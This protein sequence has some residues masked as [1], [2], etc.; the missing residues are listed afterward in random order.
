MKQGL[1]EYRDKLKT[2]MGISMLCVFFL[3]FILNILTVPTLDDLGYQINSGLLDILHREYVQYMTWTGRT[4]A[5]LIAR[6]FLALPKIIFN[7]CN[8]LCFVHLCSLVCSHAEGK[9]HSDNWQLFLISALLIWL[10]APLFGQTCLWETGS[11]NYLWT[12]MIVMQFLLNYRL[13]DSGEENDHSLLWMFAAGIPAGW[14]NENTGGALIMMI[15]FFTVVQWYRKRLRGWMLAGL[16]GTFTGFAALLLAPGNQ[17]RALDFASTN[18]KAYDLIHDFYGMLEVFQDGQTC[19]W[20]LIA[21]GIGLMLVQ[22]KYGAVRISLFYAVSGAAAVGA[23]ILSPVPVLYDRSMF[24]SAILLITS[25]MVM[26][27]ETEYDVMTRKVISAFTV[28]MLCF[29]GFNYLRTLADLSYTLYQHRGREAYTRTQKMLGNLNPTVPLIYDEFLTPYNAM[30]GLGDLSYYRLFWPNRNYAESHG[31]ESVQ[32]TSL[33]KWNLLYRDGDPALMNITDLEEYVSAVK[34]GNYTLFIN[35]SEISAEKYAEQLGVLKE[36]GLKAE[37]TGN[38]HI[39]AVYNGQQMA[40]QSVSEAETYLDGVLDNGD[41]YYISSNNDA[42]YC[43]IAI[44][45]CDYTNDNLGISI[46]VYDPVQA[47]V[48][49]SVTWYPE[50]DQGGIRYYV[51][52]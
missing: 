19:L 32:A 12:T 37:G 29:A 25:F 26:L 2:P 24:G 22:K 11:C 35:S 50:S 9:R 48:V 47:R 49:D 38:I 13:A 45:G 16:A 51:E 3:L 5:H 7:I 39:A 20:L 46:V 31:L 6:S 40:E 36:L 44:N 14:T 42:Y 28:C 41:Y 15:I 21:A 10:F 4:V 27:A 30:Y 17:V 33:E 52:K 8:S 23:I 18:G 34:K 43:D 1:N